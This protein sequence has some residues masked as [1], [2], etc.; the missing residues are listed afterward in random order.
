MRA[1]MV[2]IAFMSSLPAV[3][4]AAS[5]RCDA[6]PYGATKIEIA[7]FKGLGPLPPKEYMQRACR[8]KDEHKGDPQSLGLPAVGGM[9]P[10]GEQLTDYVATTNVP[11]LANNMWSAAKGAAVAPR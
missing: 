10:T 1:V 11:I 9:E 8:L 2:G 5:S 6:P 4:T 7:L 3:V